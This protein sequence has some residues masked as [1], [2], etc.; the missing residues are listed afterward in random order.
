MSDPL[1]QI[2]VVLHRTRSPENVGAV[3]RAMANFGLAHLRLADPAGFSLP[4]ARRVATHAAGL[5]EE[6]TVLPSLEEALSDAARIVA[7]SGAPGPGLPVVDPIRAAEWMVDAAASGARVALVFGNET[8]G[9]P[10]RVLECAHLVSVIPAHVG[11]TSLNVAQAVLLH[12]WEIWRALG[13][14]GVEVAESAPMRGED[15]ARLRD[16]ARRLLL[17]IGYLNPQQ[18]RK[19]LGELERLF[20]RAAPTE[21]EASLLLGLLRQLEWAVYHR[22]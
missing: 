12:A 5:V 14:A 6:A 15:L 3:A 7:T 4:H 8:S 16:G 19:I 17:D 21:R 9:L 22:P 11:H 18:P 2:T 10:R 20:V 1:Q 13:R